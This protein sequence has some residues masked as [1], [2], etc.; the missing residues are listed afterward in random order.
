MNNKKSPLTIS[1]A[2]DRDLEIR[3]GAIER[4]KKVDAAAIEKLTKKIKKE[5]AEIEERSKILEQQK[6]EFLSLAG[7]LEDATAK[8]LD[9]NAALGPQ[10]EAGKITMAEHAAR[11]RRPLEIRADERAK[12]QKEIAS[13]LEVIRKL[14]RDLKQ[15]I[16]SAW[17]S[18]QSILFM[19]SKH[20]ENTYQLV[21]SAAAELEKYR[22]PSFEAEACHRKITDLDPD[23]PQAHVFSCGSI[24]E[25]EI[26]ALNSIVLPEHFS[27]LHGY[28]DSLKESGFDFAK[29]KIQ[30]SYQ[31]APIAAYTTD[32]GFSFLS[33]RKETDRFPVTTGEI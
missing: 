21:K 31:R 23:A 30:A 12:F 14:D 33:L 15:L 9:E 28:V 6:S 32:S 4:Q 16:R 13:T 18:R 29:K 5:N 7:K 19:R 24:E 17:Q 25:L 27:Q 26:L 2:F 20:F 3:F 8:R 10:L 22:A 1:T 11:Y